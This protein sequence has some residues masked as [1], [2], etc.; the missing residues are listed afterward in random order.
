MRGFPVVASGKPAGVKAGGKLNVY[1]EFAGGIPVTGFGDSCSASRFFYCAKAGPEERAGDHPT[2]KPL[3]LMR[4]LTRLVT[5]PGGVVLDPF[6]GSGSTGVAAIQ[7]GF[8]FLGF[9]KDA[10]Y[11]GD[12]CA[13]RLEAAAK[14]LTL[15]E[16]RAGQ[17][18]LFPSTP[19]TPS[20][21]R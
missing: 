3:D 16:H 9:D 5:P 20:T 15:A 18:V 13:P 2:V 14:G 21:E 10:H 11:A 12:I 7:Q 4:Y 6:S 8:R 19:S 17:E 1:G